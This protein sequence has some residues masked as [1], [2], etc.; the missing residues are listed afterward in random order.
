MCCFGSLLSSYLPCR[1][2]LF[3]TNSIKLIE[4]LEQSPHNLLNMIVCRY[5]YVVYVFLKSSMDN[6]DSP[7][8]YSSW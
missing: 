7:I 3:Q 4:T 2:D 6:S 1:S 8:M 5:Y